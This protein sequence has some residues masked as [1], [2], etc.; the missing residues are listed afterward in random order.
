[1]RQAGS[2][3]TE[4]TKKAEQS[5]QETEKPKATSEYA[6]CKYFKCDKYGNEVTGDGY[7]D[8][9]GRWID[10]TS[11]EPEPAKAQ[12][13]EAVIEST[14]TVAKIGEA[15]T[16]TEDEFYNEEV[17]RELTDF[18]FTSWLEERYGDNSSLDT[19]NKSLFTLSLEDRH[20]VPK[21][22]AVD[23]NGLAKAKFSSPLKYQDYAEMQKKFI[24]MLSE[25]T[26][27]ELHDLEDVRPA[28][29]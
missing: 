5:K 7:Y 10:L 20:S 6:T 9:S 17:A 11:F 16:E 19:D 4:A 23:E 25:P 27:R 15:A 1:M 18:D 29:R 26:R 13:V 21:T 12:A 28:R 24:Y 14:V 22:N 3:G 2:S 8:E